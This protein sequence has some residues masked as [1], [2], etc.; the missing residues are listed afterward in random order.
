MKNKAFE[1]WS[2]FYLQ[3]AQAGTEQMW[4][5]ET[6]IRLIKGNYIPDIDKTHEGKKVLE[7]GIPPVLG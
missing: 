4:P 3:E 6:L 5:S 7:V 2:E 1:K